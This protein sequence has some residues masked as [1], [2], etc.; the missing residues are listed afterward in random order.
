MGG[1]FN[2]AGNITAHAEF[3]VFADPEA[4]QQVFSAGLP[5]LI[6][7]GLDVTQKTVWRRASWEATRSQQA[8]PAAELAAVVFRQAFEERNLAETYL[9]D[10]LAVAVALDPEL[11]RGEEVAVAVETDEQHRGMT[12]IVGPGATKVAVEVDVA[13][14]FRRFSDRLSLNGGDEFDGDGRTVR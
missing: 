4:A 3:N 9:H 8:D 5:N 14:F 7:V 10:P 1:A 12:R 6:A 11:V 13:S 2:V